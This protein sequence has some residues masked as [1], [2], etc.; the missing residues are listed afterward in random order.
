MP[1]GTVK[2]FNQKTKFGFIIDDETKK[3][4]Y[5]H[6]KSIE[7][8]VTANDRVTYELKAATRGEECVNVKKITN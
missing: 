7:G 3:E 4:Y 2:F 5:A 1:T 8:E 6:A